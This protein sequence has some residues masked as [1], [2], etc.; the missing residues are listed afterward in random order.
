MTTPSSVEI[1]EVSPRDGLQNEQRLFSTSEKLDLIA[2]ALN[3]GVRRLEVASFVN[4]RRVPQMADAEDVVARLP[5]RPDVTYIGLVL[6]VRGARRALETKIDQLGAVAIATD[7]F[8]QKNQ[9]QTSK[10]SVDVATEIVALAQR[11]GR[12]AQITLSAAFGCPFEGEVSPLRVAEMAQRAAEA[13]P[14]EIALADTIGV[15]IP[16]QVTSVISAVKEAAPETPVRVHFHNTRNTAIANV[17][18]AIECGAVVVDSSIGGIGGCPFAPAA[19]GNVATEDVLYLLNKWGVQTGVNLEAVI[20][21][22]NRLTSEKGLKTPGMVS[23]AGDFPGRSEH[24]EPS[25]VRGSSA[26]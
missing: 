13:G 20:G 2:D 17:V 21:A 15:A 23:K 4:P 7:T 19:T 16:A 22:A 12:S 26:V 8:A 1:V 18:A 14:V 10:E 5:D 9:G 3:A 6:N 11:E 24:R 25:E